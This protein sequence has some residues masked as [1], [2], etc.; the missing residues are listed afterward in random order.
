MCSCDRA[1]ISSVSQ[2]TAWDVELWDN[3]RGCSGSRVRAEKNSKKLITWQQ[4][5]GIIT[6]SRELEWPGHTAL[7]SGSEGNEGHKLSAGECKGSV[8]NVFSVKFLPIFVQRIWMSFG[9]LQWNGKVICFGITVLSSISVGEFRRGNKTWEH[10]P[11]LMVEVPSLGL[12]FTTALGDPAWCKGK[13][14]WGA[15]PVLHTWMAT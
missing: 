7:C 9:L 3:P 2:S 5:I 11:G 12:S 15:L 14:A 4:V 13:W 10:G 8:S 1:K 6:G